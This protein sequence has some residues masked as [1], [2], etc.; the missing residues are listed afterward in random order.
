MGLKLTRK[1]YTELFRQ[2]PSGLIK[3]SQ[4]TS[5]DE[6][7]E[8]ASLDSEQT[9]ALL[10]VLKCPNKEIDL[11]RL[12]RVIRDIDVT[13]PTTPGSFAASPVSASQINLSWSASTDPQGA[14][15]E[16]NTG[17]AGYRLYRNGSLRTTTTSLS[18]SDTGLTEYTQYSYYVTAIDGATPANESIASAVLTPRTLDATAPTAPVI[19]ASATGQS[20]ISVALTTASTDAGSGVSTY[21]LEYKRSADSTWTLDSAAL[22]SGSFPRSI[23]GLTGSTAYDTRCRATDNAGN[24]GSFSATS[25]ATTSASSSGLTITLNMATESA[26]G[27]DSVVAWESAFMLNDGRV[28]SFGAG[29]HNNEF[30]NAVR[31]LDPVQSPGSLVYTEDFPHTYTPPIF[32]AGSN[33]WTTTHDNHPSCYM[34]SENKM[35]KFGHGIFEFTGKTWFR[36]NRSPSTQLNTTWIDQS[37]H[38]N[39]GAVYNPAYAW[40]DALD[41]GC[42]YGVDGGGA[43]NPVTSCLTTLERSPSGSAQ[44]WRLVVTSLASQGIPNLCDARNTA[45][46]IGPYYYFGGTEAN[47]DGVPS[48]P[49]RFYKLDLRTKTLVSTLTAW[50]S[51]GSFPQLIYNPDTNK[52]YLFGTG[53][54]EYNFSSDTWTNV[55][56]SNYPV[57]GGGSPFEFLRACYQRDRKEAYFSG[58]G[59]FGATYN[60]KWHRLTFPAD[61]SR[62]TLVQ[63]PN[64]SGYSPFGGPPDTGSGGTKHVH[65]QWHPVLK[66]VY[67]YGGDG[68]HGSA[69]YS[70]EG[71]SMGDD[72]QTISTYQSP[73]RNYTRDS[74]FIGDQ[75]SIDPYAATPRWRLEEPYFPRNISGS[76]QRRPPRTCQKSL[77]WDTSRNKFWSIISTVRLSPYIGAD[78]N[79]D[80]WANGETTT[81]VVD[82]GNGSSTNYEHT[83]TFS[84]VPNAAGAVDGSPGTA[85]TWTFETDARL[86]FRT[87]A[88]TRYTGNVLVTG[89][90]DERVGYWCYDPRNDV[91]VGLGDTGSSPSLFIFKC[92][93]KTYEWRVLSISGF[94]YFNA[95]SS[96][97]DVVDGKLYATAQ[98]RTSAGSVRTSRMLRIDLAAALSRA[99]G[100][101]LPS[102]DYDH[103]ALP[104]SL[105]PA[106]MSFTGVSGSLPADQTITGATSGATAK[107]YLRAANQS[108]CAISHESATPFVIGETVT[109]S[110]FSATLAALSDGFWEVHGGGTL[111]DVPAKWQE[112]TGVMALNREVVFLNAY[113]FVING[114]QTK[115][116]VYNPDRNSFR[117]GQV[118]PER[119]AANSW[120]ALPDTNEVL[121]GLNTS[122]SY[123]NRKLWRFR[124]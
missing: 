38:P 110:G 20:S 73:S 123:S 2:T 35:V 21:R 124:P 122:G 6:A 112:H 27:T 14:T 63:V 115:V 68:G 7:L 117:Q 96:C 41:I 113:G 75:Y 47:A 108:F 44:P 120:C 42:F 97:C 29:N 33:R 50:P 118:P 49:L 69:G 4:H 77:V 36:G 103:Q 28:C 98:A 39:F 67:T 65:W 51:N 76:L 89:M 95:S 30:T 83:G 17:V 105:S 114:G 111:Q 57:N 61:V 106:Y 119:F 52:L 72:G 40:C 48:G 62:Y 81:T 26:A 80:Q 78:G 74:S 19:T 54:Y 90:A 70:F 43:G 8:R 87:G 66:R 92:A 18:F 9:G 13:R 5:D 56:P 79:P 107:I 101:T 71:R 100:S 109:A 121:V 88:T 34:P 23:S 84:W 24:V 31:I 102:T 94:N 10:Y 53:L 104:W 59:F 58:G 93:T 55:T 64:T 15:N 86:I 22:T 46:C 11:S 37:A 25:S 85:G 12:T 60:W 1:G 82:P 91:I 32:S 116:S 45:V 3:V 16:S 99:N